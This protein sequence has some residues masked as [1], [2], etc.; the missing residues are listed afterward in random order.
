[1]NQKHDNEESS[2]NFECQ[3]RGIK[4]LEAEKLALM[5]KIVELEAT[6]DDL[7][8]KNVHLEKEIRQLKEN[9]NYPQVKILFVREEIMG[10][11]LKEN[12]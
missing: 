5:D 8:M 3:Q 4:T 1:M 7:K 2:D 11:E 6:N 9:C 10:F 12:S